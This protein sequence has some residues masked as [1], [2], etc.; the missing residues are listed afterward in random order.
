MPGEPKAYWIAHVNI[1]DPDAYG[2]Y[3][4][5]ATPIFARFGARVL[6][7]GGTV[8]ALE[9]ASAAR[10]VV[11]EFPSLEAASACYHSL[12]YQDARKSRLGAAEVQLM[13][14]EGA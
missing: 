5:A 14:V 3:A 8:I 6:A 13:I 12:E 11:I 7:R 2:R 1:A 4:A 9:G 10:N